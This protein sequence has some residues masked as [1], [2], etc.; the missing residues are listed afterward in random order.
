MNL[1][2]FIAKRISNPG[3][4][5][6]SAV[7]HKIAITSVA[8][9]LAIMMIAFFVLGGFQE[10]IKDKIFSFSGHIQIKKFSLNNSYEEEPIVV[11]PNRLKAV[12]TD[13]YVAHVQEY[14]HKPGLISKDGEVYGVLFKGVAPS[15]NEA[16]FDKYMVEGEFIS[17][18]DSTS[19]DVMVSSKMAKN[20][21]L[22]IGDKVINYFIMDPPKTR[23]VTVK[24]IYSTGLDTFD[25]QMMIGD[26]N[27]VRSLNGWKN[28]EVGGYEVYLKNID[29]IAA[30]DDAI[31]G[32]LSVEHY[33]E[34]VDEK[35]VQ[36]FDWLNLLSKNVSIFIWLILLVA[37][38]NMVSVLFILI[39]ERTQM[40]GTFKALG[41]SNSLIR[42]IFSYNGIRLVLK[43]LLVG[44]AIAIGFALLQ[45]FF[46]IIPLDAANYYMEYVPIE[47]DWSVTIGLNLLTLILVSFVLIIP[48][49]IIARIKP[50]TA[51]RFD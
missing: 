11:D 37:S 28:D 19:T 26:I 4:N 12:A 51:I 33:T 8:L 42:R 27:V 16:L 6:F 20:L 34:R 47:W 30:A 1:P 2:Y 39:M 40:I 43:G 17:F 21:G 36:I 45:D 25:D 14:A 32:E 3:D 49:A 7:I 24:G 35:F 13:P 23:R 18:N 10:N 29:D 41:A 46:H 38:F 9:G 31:I 48:T 50:V 44:N 22:K 15:F 5:S